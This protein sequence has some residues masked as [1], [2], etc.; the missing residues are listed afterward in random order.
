MTERLSFPLPYWAY[1]SYA[2]P[3]LSLQITLQIMPR[4]L[5]L[6]TS[7]WMLFASLAY[8][9]VTTEKPESFDPAEA[10]F[11]AFVLIADAK[12]LKKEKKTV[13]ANE[14]FTLALSIYN[15]IKTV[16]PDYNP[17]MVSRAIRNL[18]ADIFSMAGIVTNAQQTRYAEKSA[19]LGKVTPPVARENKKDLSSQREELDRLYREI[20]TLKTK[21]ASAELDRGENRAQLRTAIM[22]LEQERAAKANA[23]LKAEMD[24][25]QDKLSIASQERDAMAFAV[26]KSRKQYQQVLAQNKI[27]QADLQLARTKEKEL[28]QK[29]LDERNINNDLVTSLRKQK[30]TLVKELNDM[31]RK[32]ESSRLQ[33]TSLNRQLEESQAIVSELQAE[34]DS[35]LIERD[36]MSDLL[37]MSDNERSKKLIVQNMQLGKQLT[38]ALEKVE[39]L[40]KEENTAKDQMLQARAELAHAKKSINHFKNLVIDQNRRIDQYEEKLLN[41]QASLEST[42]ITADNSQ[43]ILMLRE[44]A[45]RQIQQQKVRK[46]AKKLLVENAKQLGVLAELID[47]INA[48]AGVDTTLTEEEKA[49]VSQ[50]PGT[51]SKF[52]TAVAA[53]VDVRNREQAKLDQQTESLTLAGT[54]AF[55]KQNYVVAGQCFEYIIEQNPGHIDS[56]LSL[57]VISMRLKEMEKAAENFRAAIAMRDS[58]PYAHR[59]L[60][61]TLYNDNDLFES[62]ACFLRAV[63]LDPRDH[64]SYTYLGN[65]AGMQNEFD[66]AEA[67]YT[68]AIDINPTLP[69]PFLNMAKI[70]AKQGK[71]KEARDYYKQALENGAEADTQLESVINSLAKN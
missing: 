33:I 43:E 66:T 41:A 70:R 26:K 32:W 18:E 50:L 51:S 37:A 28:S 5:F 53:P 4:L 1:P 48:V 71:L 69:D 21:L 6:A 40:S 62:Q 13:E 57:G 11:E 61:V 54:T 27:L 9:Q 20:Q 25:L 60:G 24:T 17:S 68:T 15:S 3:P 38:D 46:N 14:K 16:H 49:L 64:T 47:P 67:N 19:L 23:P 55:L 56:M 63:Q 35:L 45:Q 31:E 2:A 39:M 7:V 30:K 36:R 44:I 58:M 8:A 65:I 59:M 52:F 42:P 10:Y 29:L 22:Q 12:K 34:R